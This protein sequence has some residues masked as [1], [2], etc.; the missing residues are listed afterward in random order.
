MKKIIRI[1]S[2]A[3]VLAL[4]LV[5]LVATAPG[6]LSRSPIKIITRNPVRS[7]KEYPL[8]QKI[9]DPSYACKNDGISIE[10][11]LYGTQTVLLTANPLENLEPEI[12]Q[13]SLAKKGSIGLTVKD[14][15]TITI[16]TQNTT[17]PQ[18]LKQTIKMIP[19]ELCTKFPII[20]IASYEGKLEQKQPFA[21]SVDKIIKIYMSPFTEND[22]LKLGIFSPEQSPGEQPSAIYN[23][24]EVNLD[25]IAK[26]S[27]ASIIC[28]QKAPNYN[29][30]IKDLEMNIIVSKDG[31]KGTYK[32]QTKHG[33]GS[34]SAISGTLDFRPKP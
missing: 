9:L 5:T 33:L 26:V 20:P 30:R 2:L 34:W 19:D 31:L 21:S 27:N 13:K 29:D 18:K 10:W 32:G 23:Y 7:E 14:E 24:P 1:I 11:D 17:S 8:N 6:I 25:C 15:V 28:K 4:G 3:I 12:K 22:E 16:Q